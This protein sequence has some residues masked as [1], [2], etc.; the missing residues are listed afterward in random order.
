MGLAG[1]NV[2]VTGGH[3]FIGSHLVE[4]L[5]KKKCN[6]VVV[7]LFKNPNSYFFRQNLNDK[8]IFEYCDVT[9]F[10]HINSVVIKHEIN[11]VFHAAAQAIVDVAYYNPLNTF[12][13]NVMGTA[14]ILESCRLY[15]KTDGVLI[16][17][18]DKVYSKLSRVDEKMPISGDHPYEVSKTSADLIARS[19][20]KTYDMPVVVTRF[21][22]VY[23]EGDLNFS[24]IIP[25]IMK[26]IVKGEALMIRS[27][28]KYVR[29]YV[30]VGDVVDATLSLAQ[31]IK[32]VKGEAFNISS[33]EN[34]SVLEVI[35]RIDGILKVKTKYKILSRATNEI[36]V[37]SV[38]FN[39]I[40]R[41]LDWKP[42]NNFK[43]AIPSVFDWYKDYFGN[44]NQARDFSTKSNS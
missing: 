28:G 37:Q 40:K 24:R 43:T 30:Y 5:V 9:N 2:L 13:D 3:G 39:K 21:G 20:F 7:D 10:K 8:V 26:S 29:D 14:N 23:G 32:S 19:Y 18:T 25:G 41:V 31:N 17:S 16:T 4:S 1:K 33:L 12:Y 35:K 22:N 44:I 11:F 27:N 36:P 15:G 38:N 34:L 42:T 6:V